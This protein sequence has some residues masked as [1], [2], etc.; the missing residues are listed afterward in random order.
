MRVLLDTSVYSL[1]M[2]NHSDAVALV[3]EADELIL[4]PITVG[5]LFAGFA[6][7]RKEAEN[8]AVFKEFL[9]SPRVR[10]ITISL[11]TAD[12]YAK[13]LNDLRALGK[14]IPTNDMW[15]AACAMHEG[16][17]LATSD[18]HFRLV[19]GLLCAFVEAKG[20]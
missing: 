3:R 17:R 6:R 8:R 10:L 19:P 12:F 2:R 1:A 16:A 15:I 5:E 9:R 11:D 18:R 14:P 13:L 4:C 7:G 20:D